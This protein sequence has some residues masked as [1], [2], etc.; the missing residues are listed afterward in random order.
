MERHV[1]I[2][3]AN[4]GIGLAVARRVLSEHEGTH[5]ILGS[6]EP[7]RG[8]DAIHSLLSEG[9]SSWGE[10]LSLLVLDTSSD[11]SVASAA[12]QLRA[13]LSASGVSLYAIVNN[14]GIAAGTVSQVLNVNVRGPQRVDAAFL[15]LLDQE[16]GRIVQMS[17]GA[18]PGCVAASSPERQLFFMDKSIKWE[19]IEALMKEVE[20]YPHGAKDLEAHGFGAGASVYGLSKALL[21]TYTQMLAQQ[22]PHLKINSCSPGLIATDLVSSFVPWYVPL[23]SAS[24]RFLATRLL[25][26]KT[27]HE[28]ASSTMHLLFN[29]LEGNGRY[30]GSDGLRSPMDK[31]RSPGTPAYDG[32]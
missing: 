7:S 9:H 6:R 13:K 32:P 28:G 3:G 5:V 31:Y 2:T 20:A 8:Q 18:A 30:Y 17:S 25:S 11:D 12:S 26:A 16:R 22:Y 23:P 10:R 19:Q 4:R 1:L 14:A 24:I 15:P 29:G 27:P 21:N